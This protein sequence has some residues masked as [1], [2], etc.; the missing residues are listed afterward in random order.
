AKAVA[1]QVTQESLDTGLIY[2]PQSQILDAS[3]KTASKIAE[4]IFDQ[5]LAR[6]QRPKDIDAH[7]RSMAY[8]PVYA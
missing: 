3:L 2:P 5:G 4:Y 8:K 7:I 1:E 6:I